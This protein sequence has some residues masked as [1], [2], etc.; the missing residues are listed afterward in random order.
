MYDKLFLLLLPSFITQVGISLQPA[1]LA[2]LPHV[3][4][5][6]VITTTETVSFVKLKCFP[7]IDNTC[8]VACMETN[9]FF[10]NSINEYRVE[11]GYF[12]SYIPS[13]FFLKLQQKAMA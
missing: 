7:K 13:F 12:R 11:K 10:S 3:L 6:C 1:T 4:A 2:Q 9:I 8:E 5:N